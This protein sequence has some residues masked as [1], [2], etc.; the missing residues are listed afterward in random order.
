[1]RVRLRLDITKPIP[2]GRIVTFG[3]VG[4]MWV[5]FKYE[6]LQW[7]CFNCGIIGHLERDCVSR[8]RARKCIGEAQYG[9]WLRTS[10]FVQRHRASRTE[11]EA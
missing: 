5:S 10:E 8:L 7:L 3:S 6:R 11:R 2:R 4:K 9:A 1:M